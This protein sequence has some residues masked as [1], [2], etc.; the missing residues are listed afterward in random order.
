MI[1]SFLDILV[2]L[3]LVAEDPDYEDSDEENED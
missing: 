1:M 3:A 2:A